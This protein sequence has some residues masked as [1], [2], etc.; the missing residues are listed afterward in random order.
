MEPLRI[1][2]TGEGWRKDWENTRKDLSFIYEKSN[3][4]NLVKDE[5]GQAMPGFLLTAV[6]LWLAGE[7]TWQ[8]VNPYSPNGY[9]AALFYTLS[10]LSLATGIPLLF[11]KKQK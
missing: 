9:V 5:K 2:L 6:G 1:Y 7:G 8:L 10:G 4:E 11:S 3:L